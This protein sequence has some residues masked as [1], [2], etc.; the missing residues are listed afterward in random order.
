MKKHLFFLMAVA[1][2]AV[3]G[4][5]S[6]TN[7]ILNEEESSQGCR[8]IIPVH[9]AS[10]KAVTVDETAHT[11]T[12]FFKTDENVYIY[13]VTKSTLDDAVLH[14]S[15]EGSSTTLEGTPNK[16]YESSDE[17]Q[18]LYNTD[19][20]G[21]VD[22]T[23]QDGSIEKVTDA[24]TGIVSITGISGGVISTTS[25]TLENL[26]SIYRLT[27]KYGDNTLNVR[28]VVITSMG[29]KLQ[30]SYN[31]VDGSTTYGPVI[32]SS[33]TSHVHLYVA[34][35]FASNPDDNI[36][37]QVIDEDGKV[38]T[39]TK[40]APADGFTNGMLYASTISV[41]PHV[42]SVSADRQVYIAPG[43]LGKDGST[44]SFIEPYGNWGFGGGAPKEQTKTAYFSWT[45]A[46]GQSTIYGIP[47]WSILS[48]AEW[49]YLTGISNIVDTKRP[50]NEGVERCYIVKTSDKY[51][52]LI[53]PDAATSAD[54]A[55]LSAYSNQNPYNEANY[56]DYVA[57][58]FAF[59][60]AT[61]GY[62]SAWDNADQVFCWSST[63]Y[64]DNNF[65]FLRVRLQNSKPDLQITVGNSRSYPA[66]LVHD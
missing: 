60:E 59:L 40:Q 48:S 19:A 18:V 63:K 13:N 49:D 8:I 52:L 64:N 25:T 53:P 37:F 56:I 54:V 28:S 35:R 51:G 12:A 3:A 11:S 32:A 58:G 41:T 14:P 38:Y 23:A 1:M 46:N 31:V 39:G 22:Y 17:V 50:M 44:Y 7:E 43:N 4:L 57:K 5:V 20:A 61:G 15:T 66:R 16:E 2:V 30:T 21:V 34:L 10:T 62:Q 33:S 27:F 26:Q 36:L 29:G 6:C 65:Y 55:G 47:G 42:F 9:A 45:A 24:G